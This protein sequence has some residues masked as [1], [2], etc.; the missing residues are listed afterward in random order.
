MRAVMCNNI[1]VPFNM[2]NLWFQ[3]QRDV[4]KMSNML[5]DLPGHLLI[6]SPECCRSSSKSQV[7]CKKCDMLK[8]KKVSQC[9][10]KEEGQSFSL[11]R[12][13]HHFRW[14]LNE[15]NAAAM[16]LLQLTE[17]SKTCFDPPIC[18]WSFA[19]FPCCIRKYL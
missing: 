7:V 16:F 15:D 8:V 9:C 13:P 14:C 4:L 1:Q 3:L 11:Q 12:R 19:S 10:C 5:S 2:I 6:C 18:T 17:N